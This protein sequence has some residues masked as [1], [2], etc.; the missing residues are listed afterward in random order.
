MR[1]WTCLSQQERYVSIGRR[2]S[3]VTRHE[4]RGT[5]EERWQPAWIRWP[6][7]RPRPCGHRTPYRRDM[8]TT[9]DVHAM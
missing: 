2:G 3:F 8:H 7:A 9:Q 4:A 5:G 1:G 6:I